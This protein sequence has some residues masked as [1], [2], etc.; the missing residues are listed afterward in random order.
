MIENRE[1]F[2]MATRIIKAGG[3][4]VASADGEDLVYLRTLQQE[5]EKA[6]DNAVNG[7]REQGHSWGYIAKCL[8]VSRQ[9]CQKK[10]GK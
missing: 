3:K 10:W 2:Q 6:M 8:G 5:V 4:R 7:L 9:Y 1:F